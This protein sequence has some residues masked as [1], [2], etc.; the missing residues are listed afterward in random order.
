MDIFE[1]N[2]EAKVAYER[3]AKEIFAAHTLPV[4]ILSVIFRVIML[5]FIPIILFVLQLLQ[6]LT[7]AASVASKIIMG[8]SILGIILSVVSL[9]QKA[10]NYEWIMLIM[11]FIFALIAYWLPSILTWLYAHVHVTIHKFK[12]YVFQLKYIFNQHEMI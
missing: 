8:L 9:F 6:W 11:S 7:I 10:E 3:Q 1:G 5:P 4:K 12:Y 2:F